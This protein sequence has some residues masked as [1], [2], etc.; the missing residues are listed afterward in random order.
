MYVFDSADEEDTGP[1]HQMGERD[2]PGS[3]RQQA[4]S[5]PPYLGDKHWECPERQ[6]S[7]SFY[8]ERQALG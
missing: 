5:L 2:L 4:D 7:D 8:G 6:F 3:Q 1:R